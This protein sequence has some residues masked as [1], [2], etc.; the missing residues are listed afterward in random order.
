MAYALPKVKAKKV[1]RSVVALDRQ[2]L[3]NLSG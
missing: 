1:R 2:M 3:I